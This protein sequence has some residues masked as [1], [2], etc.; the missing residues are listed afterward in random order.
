MTKFVL[1][2]D[3][4]IGTVKL[5]G[6]YTAERVIEI[7]QNNEPDAH[8]TECEKVPRG[9]HTCKY[10]GQIAEGTFADLLCEACRSTFGHSLFSEL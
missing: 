5:D 10:C 8:W 6:G 2:S 9:K 3:S 7:M 4:Q 1:R